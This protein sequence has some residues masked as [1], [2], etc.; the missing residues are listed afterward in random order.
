MRIEGQNPTLKKEGF[1]ISRDVMCIEVVLTTKKNELKK[2]A[3][4]PGALYTHRSIMNNTTTVQSKKLM[5]S[6]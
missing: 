3:L 1:M 5:F 2:F 6:C 4:C